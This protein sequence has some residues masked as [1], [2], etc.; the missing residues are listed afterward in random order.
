MIL[1]WALESVLR[2]SPACL[3]SVGN[4]IS[5]ATLPVPRFPSPQA[6]R[7][8]WPMEALERD[9]RAG[10]GEKPGISSTFSSPSGFALSGTESPL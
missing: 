1:L 9:W 7:W 2:L 3:C 8:R 4:Y 6:A 10:R 5:Q